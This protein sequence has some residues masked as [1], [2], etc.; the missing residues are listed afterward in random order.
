MA[1]QVDAVAAWRV[2]LYS[3]PIV[4]RGIW[5]GRDCKAEIARGVG[6]C[7]EAPREPT[8]ATPGKAWTP[9]GRSRVTMYIPR[10]MPLCVA[11]R[12][13]RVICPA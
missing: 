5:A 7:R 10:R 3:R 6:W 12:T 8:V 9:T 1:I 4:L 2:R 13:D 11:Y